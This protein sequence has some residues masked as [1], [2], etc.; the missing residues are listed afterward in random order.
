VRGKVE[1]FELAE[2]EIPESERTAARARARAHWLLALGELEEPGRR[3]CLV[4]TAG[5]PGTGKSTLAQNLARSGRFR[6]VRSDVVR[7]ELAGLSPEQPAPASDRD[8]IYSPAWSDRTYAECLRRAELALFEGER[9]LVDA[10]FRSETRRRPFL[11]AAARWAVPAVILAC[12]TDPDT[13]RSRL[14]NRKGDASDAD[15]E[16]Y[17]RAAPEW[18]EPAPSTRERF[19]VIDSSGSEEATLHKAKDTLEHQGL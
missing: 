8:R 13:A 16:F 5:L 15:W 1:G 10:N 6:L 11:E 12:Q 19:W 7:K 17:R 4:L 2:N 14:A 3:P 9:I 18:E